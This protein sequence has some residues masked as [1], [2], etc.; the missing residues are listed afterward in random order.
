MAPVD[1]GEED[2]DN[3]EDDDSGDDAGLSWWRED[4][5]TDCATSSLPA[6]KDKQHF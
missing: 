4:A 5:D 2:D 3:D 1:D 6:K